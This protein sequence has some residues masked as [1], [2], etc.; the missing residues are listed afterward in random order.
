[1]IGTHNFE[2]IVDLSIM[3]AGQKNQ[4]IHE[5][6]LET[7]KHSNCCK[8]ERLVVWTANTSREAKMKFG[9]QLQLGLY[10]PWKDHVSNPIPL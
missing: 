6:I 8:T 9:R 10:P 5:E 7:G 2:D 1:L 4:R 3:I